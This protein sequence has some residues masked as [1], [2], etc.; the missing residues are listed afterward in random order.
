MAQF[1]V[2]KGK[3]YKCSIELSF[4][5]SFA[6]N[7]AIAVRLVDAGFIN[8]DVNG[9][10]YEREAEGTWPLDDISA[11][12]PSQITHVEEMTEAKETDET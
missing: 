6:G 9:D 3:R 12:M 10:G 2:K 8:V 4:L 1:T 7:E 5:E 11:E